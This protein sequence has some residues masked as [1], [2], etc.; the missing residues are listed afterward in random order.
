MRRHTRH[1]CSQF[2]ACGCTHGW[3]GRGGR[4]VGLGPALAPAPLPSLLLLWQLR[5]LVDRGVILGRVIGHR[6]YEDRVLVRAG[7][8]IGS[9]GRAAAA[10]AWVG[11]SC[12]HGTAVGVGL[13]A[14]RGVHQSL[15]GLAGPGARPAAVAAARRGIVGRLGGCVSRASTP[16]ACCFCSGCTLD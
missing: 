16:F 14:R 10:V 5:L 11:S 13:T 8:S 9:C 4:A 3:F 15:S 6:R 7:W 12:G 2:P 1:N